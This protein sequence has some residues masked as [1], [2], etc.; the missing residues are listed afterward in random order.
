MFNKECI[1]W[2]NGI[3]LSV[4]LVLSAIKSIVC[5][6]PHF[7]HGHSE[8]AARPWT[9]FKRIISLH[10]PKFM[11][12]TSGCNYSLCLMDAIPLYDIIKAY[13]DIYVSTPQSCVKQ[14]L[15]CIDVNICICFYNLCTPDDGCEWHPKHVEWL[16]S[17][18]NKDCLELHLVGLLNA[19]YTY[20]CFI[21]VRGLEL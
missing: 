11:T 2:W 21:Y 16:G 6:L 12:C 10:S 20:I 17:I 13:I 14:N 19:Q 1:F 9:L 7:G 15:L 8:V 5:F 3:L 18:I 4:K